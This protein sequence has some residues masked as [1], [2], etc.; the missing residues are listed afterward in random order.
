MEVEQ[1]GDS[2]VQQV[3]ARSHN[4]VC[5]ACSGGQSW[6]HGDSEHTLHLP[7]HFTALASMVTTR[8]SADRWDGLFLAYLHRQMRTLTCHI[9]PGV[10]RGH[11]SFIDGRECVP[12]SVRLHHPLYQQALPTRAVLVQTGE[13]V[14]KM[15]KLKYGG[16]SD[17]ALPAKQYTVVLAAIIFWWWWVLFC[18]KKQYWW[19]RAGLSNYISIWA[20]LSSW[21]PFKG[22]LF[23]TSLIFDYTESKVTKKFTF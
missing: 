4:S 18:S 2:H 9:Q 3:S 11:A 19:R 16:W 23:F 5:L 15:L 1:L 14:T 17:A 7:F 6:I 13:T 8:L 22:R 20:T 21:I 10:A 12:A